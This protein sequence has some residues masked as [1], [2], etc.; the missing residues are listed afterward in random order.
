[1]S[2]RLGAKPEADEHSHELLLGAGTGPLRERIRASAVDPEQTFADFA[3]RLVP[4]TWAYTHKCPKCAAYSIT[5]SARARSD[6]GTVR[7]SAFGDT[8]GLV[9]GF[10]F[11]P[12]LNYR[13]V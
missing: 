6:C 5:S 4:Q 10:S 2:D 12:S 9:P 3:Q 13:S 7:P 8:P 11:A 1:M